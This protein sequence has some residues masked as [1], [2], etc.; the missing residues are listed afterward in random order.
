MARVSSLRRPVRAT[1]RVLPAAAGGLVAG[2]FLTYVFIAPA[3]PHR[4]AFLQQTGHGYFPRAAAAAAALGAIAMG[5][6]AARGMARRHAGSDFSLGWRAM[7]TRFALL[8]AI[9]FVLLEIGERLVVR[10]PLGGLAGVLPVGLAVE[11]VVAAVVAWMLCVTEL[12]SATVTLALVPRRALR[13]ADTP[14]PAPHVDLDALPVP[15][16]LISSVTLRGPPALSPA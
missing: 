13:D 2:H 3:G 5:M 4:A 8:Q 10:A 16:Y 14:R 6:A 15:S 11:V 12:A 7:A 9:G 1:L